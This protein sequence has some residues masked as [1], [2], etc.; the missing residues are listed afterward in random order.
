M[1]TGDKPSQVGQIISDLS[2]RL[3][4]C[5]REENVSYLIH[6]PWIGDDKLEL[7]EKYFTSETSLQFS[8]DFINIEINTS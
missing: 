1:K 2:D 4:V 5:L 3:I 8:Q 7:L 6:Q